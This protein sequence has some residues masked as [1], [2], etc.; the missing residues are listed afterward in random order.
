MAAKSEVRRHICQ[1]HQA[2]ERLDSFSENT[3]IVCFCVLDGRS[4]ARESQRDRGPPGEHPPAEPRVATADAHHRQLHS[5]GISG[6]WVDVC[7]CVCDH[8]VILVRGNWNLLCVACSLCR[9]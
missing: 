4:A 3:E 8:I 1:L 7:A 9:R 5:P 6:L 2:D